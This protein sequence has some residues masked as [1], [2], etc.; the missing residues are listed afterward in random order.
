VLNLRY[1]YAKLG[2]D[3]YLGGVSVR[4][5]AGKAVPPPSYVFWDS[6]RRC[7]LHCL[8]CGAVKERYAEELTTEQVMGILDQLAELKVD[9]FGATGGEPLLR[10]DL[11]EIFAYA[12][13]R[14]VKTGIATNGFFLDEAA[15]E[16][17]E[18]A[19]VVSI[20]VSLDGPEATHNLVR[21]SGESFARAIR[22]IELLKR[23]GTP[24]LSVGT[25]VT[26]DNVGELEALRQVLLKL[27]VKLWRLAALM[28]IGRAQTSGA[29]LSGK[30]LAWLLDYARKSRS[31]SL[32]IYFAENLTFLGPW[33]RK[34][35]RQPLICPIGFT[36]CCI[37]VDGSVRGCP[38]QP[39][40]E[41]NREGS[42]LETP[43]RDIWQQGF[44]RY[45]EREILRTDTKCAACVSRNDCFG[46]CWVM[47]QEG[48]HC[49]YE[50]LNH[51]APG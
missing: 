38:E 37:G 47:R 49:I 13:H 18:R 2:T 5:K 20:Q 23:A 29:S 33:E 9:M 6:T 11:P 19:K 7:N 26:T 42:V 14:G 8:H 4:Y 15:A 30:Q 16:W 22:A 44:R 43:L 34:I 31:R 27:G 45:R 39:D 10:K 28:P 46:G 25:T 35:R 12:H 1:S 3:F 40:T 41:E 48:Q 51:V 24:I 17:I 50:M 21:G 32:N 36:A